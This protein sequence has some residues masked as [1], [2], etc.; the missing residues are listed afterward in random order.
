MERGERFYGLPMAVY[1]EIRAT[2]NNDIS[3]RDFFS[4]KKTISNTFY[5]IFIYILFSTNL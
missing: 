2:C 1:I 3:S 4:P 5:I